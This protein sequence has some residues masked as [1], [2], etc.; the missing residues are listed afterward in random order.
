MIRIG[1]ASSL[2]C[3]ISCSGVFVLLLLTVICLSDECR[4]DNGDG[5]GRNQL[6]ITLMRVRS[7]LQASNS[8]GVGGS[9]RAAI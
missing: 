9:G 3:S 8:G 7:E 2:L 6:G 4:G 5:T 1:N